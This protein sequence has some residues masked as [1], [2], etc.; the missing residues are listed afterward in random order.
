V[1]NII[2]YEINEAVTTAVLLYYTNVAQHVHLGKVCQQ[3]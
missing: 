1:T 2:K 3:Q